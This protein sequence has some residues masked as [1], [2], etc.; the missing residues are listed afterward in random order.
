VMV[1]DQGTRDEVVPDWIASTRLMADL[2]ADGING[3]TLYDFPRIFRTASDETG[4]SVALEPQVPSAKPNEALAWDNLSWNDWVILSERGGWQ[5]PFVPQV[6]AD[7]WLESRHMVNICDRWA[8]DKT[9]DLQHAFFN[10]VGY[11]SWENI[12]GIW[13]QIDDR[14][15]EALR[16]TSEIERAFAD[17]LTS[18]E[19]EPHTPVVRYGVFASKFQKNSMDNRQPQQ[20]RREWSADQVEV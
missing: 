19:W 11:E 2:G 8:H 9:D 6:T 4:H 10:G 5:Y 20:F 12:W 17:L 16:R 7:K 15:S 18:P 14:D 1:W 13:N 3:D